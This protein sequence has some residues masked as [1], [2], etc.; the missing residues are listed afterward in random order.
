MDDFIRHCLR[1]RKNPY[2]SAMQIAKVVDL[3]NGSVSNLSGY[4]V[5]QKKIK[6]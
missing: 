3:F 6:E 4:N 5:L 1:K 2:P